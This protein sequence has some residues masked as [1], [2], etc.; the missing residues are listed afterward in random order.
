MLYL[1][2]GKPPG[3]MGPGPGPGGPMPM[4]PMPM[5][6][7]MMGGELLRFLYL[8]FSI[9]IFPF[10]WNHCKTF[11]FIIHVVFFMFP[12]VYVLYVSL[13]FP[14]LMFYTYFRNEADGTSNGSS[15]GASQLGSLQTQSSISHYFI[16]RC[17]IFI[18]FCQ[19]CYS[20]SVIFL[21]CGM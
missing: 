16:I 2:G 5:G 14:F 21:L 7:P 8:Y 12:F 9:N 18:I 4:M 1:L 17:D 10:V 19:N 20:T 15:D 13:S 11:L 3:P 6:P